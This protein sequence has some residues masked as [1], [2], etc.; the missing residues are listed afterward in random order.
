MTHATNPEIGKTFRTGSFETNYHD[1]GSGV[2]APVLLLHG[3]GAGV[4]AWA[5]WRGLI[6][7]LSENFRVI[8]P[9]LV[10]FGYTTLPDPVRFEIFDTWID[11][12]LSLLDGLGIEKVH[13]VGNSFGGGLAL[14]LATRFPERLDRIVLMGAGGVKIDFTPE[15]DALWGYTPSVENM[16]NIMDIMR[17]TGR[18][19]PMNSPNCAIVP[20]SA[21]AQ[22]AFEQVFPEPRQRWLDA[23][24]VAD[25]SLAKIG[26]E[27]LIV[28]GREDRVVPV[29]AS[30]HMFDMIPNAQLHVFGKCGHWT[31]IEHATRFQQLVD[32]FLGESLVP[33]E[34]L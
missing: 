5:N 13:V 31:Q 24:I 34:V 1:V 3:S 25:E 28:H 4:S 7:V 29:E 17:T 11:Q 22:E 27:V 30:R 12:I 33:E 16:R 14:H 2:G 23:Q 20:R 19:S 32:G 9:D 15:L 26:H 10:G 6:P 21:R 18:S 8:A